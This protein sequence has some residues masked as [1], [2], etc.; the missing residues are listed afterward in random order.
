VTKPTVNAT[1]HPYFKDGGPALQYYLE[2]GNSIN[3][4]F[5]ILEDDEGCFE[6]SV[7][8]KPKLNFTS[9]EVE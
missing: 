9:F 3:L 4:S 5:P 2:A 6:I 7:I 8:L 1:T